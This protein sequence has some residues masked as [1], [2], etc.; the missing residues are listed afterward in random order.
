MS[1][2]Y[3]PPLDVRTLQRQVWNTETARRI[4]GV[5]RALD[6]LAGLSSQMSLDAIRGIVPLPRPR[7]LEQPDLDLARSTFVRLNIEDYL[8]EGNAAGL[9]TARFEDGWPATTKW[10]PAHD[11]HAMIDPQ[12]GRR[13]YWLRGREVN[14]DDVVH[15]QNGADPLNPA[16]G[17]GVVERYVRS[18]DRVALQEERERTDLSDGQVPSVAVTAPQGDYSE[19]ELDEAADKW[20]EK[21]GGPVRR[22]AFLPYG[23]E[24]TPLSWSPND[25]EAQAARKASLVDVAN[26]FN[27]DGYW[28]GAPASSHT[29]RTPGPLFLVLLRTT[30]N[31]ILAPFEDTWTLQWLPRGQRVTF[32]REEI[33][34]D[35]MATTISTLTKAT[36]GP[37]MTPNE[38]RTRIRLAPIDG[39]DELRSA[40]VEEDPPEPD[41]PIDPPNPEP[42]D[43]EEKP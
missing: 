9:V 13:R 5:G 27:L 40:A 34:E 8:L 16:R 25:A 35:D 19:E 14:R 4:P 10:Y 3:P 43:P 36:G 21:F 28:L 2:L 18:L 38:G 12:T 42:D 1:Q 22:P 15:V 26:M 37:I 17:V 39:G 7:L 30:L 6:L 11:W 41:E 20:A 24:V 32:A 31:P 23:T 33:L 29:Y